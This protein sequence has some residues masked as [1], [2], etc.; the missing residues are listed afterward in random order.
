MSASPRKLESLTV[1]VPGL[2]EIDNLPKLYED[3]THTL[4]QGEWKLE[5]LFV[6]DGSTD[7]TLEACRQLN[8]KDPRFQYIS[9]SRNFGH[10]KAVT[11]GLDLAWS[12]AVVVMDADLQ[13]PPDVVIEMIK[14]WSEGA[15]V[16]YGRRRIRKGDSFLKKAT[17]K[18]F[19]RLLQFMSGTPIP[20]DT[21]DFR[22]MDRRVVEQLRIMREQG[23]YIRG[24]VSW[25]GF[26]QR[27]VIYDRPPRHKGESKYPYFRQ[28]RL[29]WEGISAFSTWPLRMATMVGIFFSMVAFGMAVY[30]ALRKILINDFDPGWASIMVS[31]FAVGGAQLF[32]IGVVGE[33]IAKTFEEIKKRPL[34]IIRE[35]SGNA[36]KRPGSA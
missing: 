1:V 27:P 13:D 26:I 25:V 28:I 23:R 14:V 17:A 34:Y 18:A 24:M 6:D 5:I 36:E 30:Y 33:Y 12:Q 7:G 2:N 9:L 20:V 29:A 22:L 4:G 31:I 35:T 21:G 11:A 19:Y 16:V 3:L 10:Q 32:F 15:D 8:A